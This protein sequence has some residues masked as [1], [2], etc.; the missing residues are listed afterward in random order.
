MHC[1][2]PPGGESGDIA[3]ALGRFWAKSWLWPGCFRMRGYNLPEKVGR[4]AVTA[5]VLVCG[6]VVLLLVYK[7]SR[8]TPP[9]FGGVLR[10]SG[11]GY[12]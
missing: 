4:Y 7:K 2:Q 11:G 5:L 12:G 8:L 9:N 10:L 3:P 6:G 1:N